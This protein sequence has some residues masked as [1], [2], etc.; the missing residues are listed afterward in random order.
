MSNN[1]IFQVIVVNSYKE[2]MKRTNCYYMEQYECILFT[3]V[4]KEIVHTIFNLFI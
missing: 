2:T 3:F 4:L 1:I